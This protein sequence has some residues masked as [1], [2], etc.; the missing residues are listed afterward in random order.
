MGQQE[1]KLMTKEKCNPP[2]PGSVKISAELYGKLL[3][4]SEK[5]GISKNKLAE[6]LL[7]I[8]I[9]KID[10]GGQIKINMATGEIAIG[11]P[12]PVHNNGV[13]RP[14]SL[15]EP[16]VRKLDMRGE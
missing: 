2:L 12:P 5:S 4:A 10:N 15:D 7:G 16:V 13:A 1:R 11:A 14:A 8:M 9:D 6:Q 3:D